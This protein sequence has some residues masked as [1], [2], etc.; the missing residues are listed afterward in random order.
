M[1]HSGSLMCYCF[2][3]LIGDSSLLRLSGGG[4]RVLFRAMYVHAYMWCS[5]A[6]Y[7]SG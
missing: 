7:C 5:S 6:I 1:F 3:S 4:Y 2:S